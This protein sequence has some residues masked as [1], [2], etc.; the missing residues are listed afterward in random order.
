[1]ENPKL[2]VKKLPKSYPL[3]PQ[4][5]LLKEAS[6]ACGIKKGMTRAELIAS[7]T[8]CIPEFYR[9]K[10]EEAASQPPPETTQ[11]GGDTPAV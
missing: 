2:I 10:K 1:M 4:Q 3:L 7:M 11:Q 9:K 8:N 5:Q 6:T